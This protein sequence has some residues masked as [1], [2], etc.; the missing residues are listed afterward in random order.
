MKLP[1]DL[2]SAVLRSMR[3]RGFRKKNSLSN[4]TDG[5]QDLPGPTIFHVTAHKAGSQWIRK[6]LSMCAPQRMVEP[7]LHVAHFLKNPIKAGYIYPTV[8]VTKTE[9]DRVV[10]PSH[11]I[12]FVILRD[13]RDILVS[14]YFSLRYSHSEQGEIS[15]IRKALNAR[16]T[17][18]GMLWL[19]K[20]WLARDAQI[21]SS[22]STSGQR[23]IRYEDLL[24]NDIGVL[25]DV[26]IEQCGLPVDPT[27]LREY[28]LSCRFS[29]LAGRAR[30][31]EN[32]DSHLRKGVAG[33]WRNYFTVK[34]E[35]SFKKRYG[36]LLVKCGYEKSNGW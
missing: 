29:Q 5:A 22:W 11:S 28:I 10:K 3:L 32:I 26:L 9:F 2:R 15:A 18:E 8:Y 33:D 27:L 13:L 20:G 4:P 35:K 1:T 34:L 16:S 17:E 14:G 31:E 19:I 24:E 6:I 23:W 21:C 12:H 7:Q 36:N 30:G 25:E